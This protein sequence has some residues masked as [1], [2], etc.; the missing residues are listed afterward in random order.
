MYLQNHSR[1]DSSNVYFLGLFGFLSVFGLFW[2]FH[3]LIEGK[4]CFGI[5]T[6]FLL[7]YIVFEIL[8]VMLRSTDRI[9]LHPAVLSSLAT[10]G[11]WFGVT[12]FLYWGPEEKF[13]YKLLGDQAFYWMNRAMFLI[14]LAAFAL[15]RGFRSSIGAGMTKAFWNAFVFNRIFRRQFHLRWSF[16]IIC[17][18]VSLGCRLA[19]IYLGV[20]GYSS[21]YQR[22]YEL[23][24]V[25]QYLDIGSGLGRLALLGVSLAHFFRRHYH[26][27]L[28]WMMVGTLGYEIFFGF[29]SGFKSQVVVPVIIVFFAYY[30]AKGRIPK[31]W[32]FGGIFL[33]FLAY[34]VIQPFREIRQK[35]PFFQGRS[36]AGISKFLREGLQQAR[37]SEGFFQATVDKYFIEAAKRMSMTPVAARSIQYKE[38][39]GLEEDDPRFL[40]RMILSPLYAF[41]PRLVWSSKPVFNIGKWYAVR[42]MGMPEDT[43]TAIGMSPV[44]FLYFAGD[45]IFVFCGFFLFGIIQKALYR[46]LSLGSGGVIIFLVLIRPFIFI[47]HSVDTIF[48]STLRYFPIC[49]FLQ[50]F[51]FKR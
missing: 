34:A 13:L 11:L 1:L 44:G 31:T 25:R 3:P 27:V 50:W 42:V 17:L 51:L 18:G 9:L 5:L 40:R 37:L 16:I 19:Q 7:S 24:G 2:L 8:F 12:N 48:V 6:F 32:L 29:L 41:I 43:R 46:H 10:F 45:S 49:I 14:L 26:P 22:L 30:V 47:D 28:H 21:D 35:D 36:V 23:A 39:I 20:Y 38:E 33:L 15:W 4:I